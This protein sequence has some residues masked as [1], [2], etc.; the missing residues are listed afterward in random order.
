MEYQAEDNQN[1]S[2]KDAYSRLFQSNAAPR[3]T[4]HQT[5]RWNCRILSVM[6]D[7]G[8]LQKYS[9]ARF[10][11]KWKKLTGCVGDS[12]VKKCC[13]NGWELV[14]IFSSALKC[15]MARAR[16]RADDEKD[17]PMF[18]Q[19]QCIMIATKTW[20]RL[21]FTWQLFSSD[22]IFRSGE[23][24]SSGAANISIQVQS[25][26]VLRQSLVIQLL[27]YH[28]KMPQYYF[29]IKFKHYIPKD[30]PGSVE[31]ISDAWLFSS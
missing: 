20:I 23:R 12:S 26:S 1:I 21:Y 13:P 7:V 27:P 17:Q 14:L 30:G 2:T 22:F 10:T 24:Q 25:Y 8:A 4:K 16:T 3:S 9:T 31:A 11:N 28:F 6:L 15:K 5:N 18:S 19:C 29:K